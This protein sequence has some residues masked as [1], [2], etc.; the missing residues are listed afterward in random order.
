LN[1]HLSRAVAIEKVAARLAAEHEA[2][3]STT[4]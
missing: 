3:V 2:A 4:T 1:A